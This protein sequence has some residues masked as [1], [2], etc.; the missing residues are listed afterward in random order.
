MI[1]YNQ[2]M[3]RITEKMLKEKP[4]RLIVVAKDGSGDFSSLQAA[5][6][7]IPE[8]GEGETTILLRA[9]EYREKAVPGTGARRTCMRTGRKRGPSFPPP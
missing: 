8:T 4:G 1:P 6:D 9:G 7:S 3:E 2:T 5:V